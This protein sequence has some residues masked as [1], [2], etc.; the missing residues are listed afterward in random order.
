MILEVFS[1]SNDAM[2]ACCYDSMEFWFSLLHSN[3]DLYLLVTEKI[4][5]QPEAYSRSYPHKKKKKK[6]FQ[7]YE[8]SEIV[9]YKALC[10]STLANCWVK[11]TRKM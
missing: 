1:N 7:S 6:V 10:F 4:P 5:T 9:R 11:G 8:K 3:S 2:I